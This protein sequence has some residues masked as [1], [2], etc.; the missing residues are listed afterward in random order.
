MVERREHGQ[1]RLARP[2]MLDALALSD[3]ATAS[4]GHLSQERR[5]QR[6]FADARLSG[7]EDHLAISAE[8][9][10]QGRTESADLRLAPDE[11]SAGRAVLIGIVGVD[12][13]V[14]EA[15]DLRARTGCGRWA[16]GGQ[17]SIAPAVD[18]LD[19]AWRPAVIAERSPQLA[20]PDLEHRV[21]DHRVGPDSLEQ[22]HLR[23]EHPRAR[24]EA[25]KES[26]RFGGERN[27]LRPAPQPLVTQ[28]DPEVPE[29]EDACLVHRAP[30]SPD[31]LPSRNLGTS[32]GLIEPTPATFSPGEHVRRPGRR[33]R[34]IDGPSTIGHAPGRMLR[35]VSFAGATESSCLQRSTLP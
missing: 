15:R 7:Q 33:S 4:A 32:F 8:C 18:G 30:D 34:P 23:H 11:A 5:D 20:D 13:G 28:V 14:T 6:R 9:L 1:V 17:K 35:D 22:G 25:T 3:P 29:P 10:L 26:E 2:E 12:R 27:R 31:G 19:E 21:P 16:D 24:Q